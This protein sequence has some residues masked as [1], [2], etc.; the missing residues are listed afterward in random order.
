MDAEMVRDYALAASG[1]LAG[2][3]GGPSVRPYQPEGVWEAVAM[4]GSNTRDYQPDQRRAALPPQPLH[5]LEA[6]CAAGLD[7]HLQRPEPRGLHRPPRADE[8]AA[9]GARHAQR[10]AVRRG[11]PRTWPSGAQG[12]AARTPNDRLDFLPGGSSPGRF[13][14][15]EA[16]VVQASLAEPAAFYQSHPEDANE[17]VAVGESKPDPTL[18]PPTLAAWTMLANELMNLDEVLNK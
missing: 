10:P 18:D 2:E 7:G 15:E 14:A 9:P 6:R 17:L 4:P 5:L 11:R 13:R 1:L 8:H 16:Q 3:I 12:R